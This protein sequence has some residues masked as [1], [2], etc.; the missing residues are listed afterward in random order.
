MHP[1]NRYAE[2]KIVEFSF[3]IF[4][5]L[6]LVAILS[7]VTSSGWMTVL[8][9]MFCV[10][11]LTF[12]SFALILIAFGIENIARKSLVWV[13]KYLAYT[14][15]YIQA[16]VTIFNIGD[17]AGSSS[18][19]IGNFIQRVIQMILLRPAACS[20]YSNSVN[21]WIRDEIIIGLYAL[22][23]LILGIFIIK[24]LVSSHSKSA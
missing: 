13:D 8:F 2:I 19:K 11:L 7:V 17:C 6:V 9:F 10:P 23:L 15:I 16:F 5:A 20:R 18:I 4:L 21:P 1:K 22:N 12:I 3:N 24:T 14:M